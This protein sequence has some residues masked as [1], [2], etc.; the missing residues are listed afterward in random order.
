MDAVEAL[1]GYD[2]LALLPDDIEAAVE[3]G[4]KPP[5]AAINGPFTGSEGSAIAMSAAGSADP[6][7]DALTYLWSFGDGGTA[8]GI[9]R[10]TTRTRRTAITR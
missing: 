2:L 8:N 1:S 7:G 9:G 10:V 3:S 5:V 6:D 4:T